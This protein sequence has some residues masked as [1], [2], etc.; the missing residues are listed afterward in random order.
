MLI[1]EQQMPGSQRQTSDAAE[2]SASGP[3]APAHLRRGDDHGPVEA[4]RRQVLHGRQVFVR[5]AGRGV[6]DEVV[7]LSPVHV[8]EELLDHACRECAT[9]PLRP[10]LSLLCTC[11]PSGTLGFSRAPRLC[12][13]SA[14]AVTMETCRRH[15]WGGGGGEAL[16]S[17]R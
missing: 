14:V 4:R 8:T 13:L 6:H 12:C 5:R 16:A 15:D 10:L 17:R 7:Q 2:S 3:R 1:C 11:S 9:E